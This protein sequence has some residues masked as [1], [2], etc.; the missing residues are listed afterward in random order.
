MLADAASAAA[1]RNGH[2]S[3]PKGQGGSGSLMMLKG[4]RVSGDGWK[5]ASV[6]T[7]STLE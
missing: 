2:S 4:C 6:A 7:N 1:A 3:K 5:Y